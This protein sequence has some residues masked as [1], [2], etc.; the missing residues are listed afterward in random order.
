MQSLKRKYLDSLLD[1][2]LLYCLTSV[3]LVALPLVARAQTVI[4]T[5]PETEVADDVVTDEITEV[6]QFFDLS[7]DLLILEPVVQGFN[8]EDYAYVSQT[9]G[10][11]YISLSQMAQY[12]GLKYVRD[13]NNILTLWEADNE[14]VRYRIDFLTRKVDEVNMENN[15]VG[16]G[17]WFRDYDM[18]IIDQSIF[19]SS[20]FWQRL[21][22]AEVLVDPLNMQLVIKREKDFPAIGKIKAEKNR[23][24]KG[25]YS[26][27]DDGFENYE[28]DNRLFAEPVIDLSLG[29]GWGHNKMSHKTTNSDS[30]AVN[31]AMLAMGLDVNAYIQGS[32]YN[33]RKPTVRLSGSRT[34]LDNEN[35]YNLK[36]LKVGDISGLGQSY[37]TDAS[38]GRGVAVSSFKNLV[39]SADKTID[40]TGP[41]T[42]GWDVELYWNEQLIGFR[43]SGTNGEYNFPDVPVSYGLNIFK[44]V[45]YGPYGET[46]TEYE[47]YYSG[48]SPVKTG[49]FGYNVSVYQPYRYLVEDNRTFKYDGKDVPVI[50]MTGYYGATDKLT[51]MGGFTQTPSGTMKDE[52]TQQFGMAGAQYSLSGSSIQYNLEQNLDTQ[53]FG[54]HMEWQGNVYIGNIYAGYDKYNG[55]HSPVS[56][57][58]EEYLDEQIET[59]LSGTLPYN[60][61]YYLSYRTGK[62][63]DGD[64]PFENIS[65]RLSKQLMSGLN[66]SIEDNWYSYSG[67]RD[68]YNTLRAG[69]YKWWNKYTLQSYLTYRTNPDPEL[70]EI[71]TR[72]D[73]R[74]GRNT[75]MSGQWTRNMLNDMDYFSLSGGH[76]YPF[77]GLTATLETDRDFNLSAYLTY[78][79][80]FAKEPNR[81]G[82]IVNSNSKLSNTG[83]MMVEVKDEEGKPIEGVGLNANGLEKM[84][85]TDEDGVAILADLQTYEKTILS[86]DLETLI[87]ISL[88]PK[89]EYKKVV[90]R[91]GTIKTVEYEFIHRGAIEGKIAN[92]EGKR[93]FGY[94]IAAIDKDSKETAVT[95]A[96][97]DGYFI[98]DGIPYGTYS[99]I[100]SKEGK[101][102][103]EL[104]DVKVDDVAVYIEDEVVVDLDALEFF[105]NLD[106][107]IENQRIA[108]EHEKGYNPVEHLNN[109]F[110]F[111]MHKDILDMDPNQYIMT[112]DEIE[113]GVFDDKIIN[114]KTINRIEKE[115]FGNDIYSNI[116]DELEDLE[117]EIF[118]KEEISNVSPI[119]IQDKETAIKEIEN[120]IVNDKDNNVLDENKENVSS[121]I[122]DLDF[123]K[124]DLAENEALKE[125]IGN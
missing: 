109:T 66:V 10:K 123:I 25:F 116:E 74:T 21:L 45:F 115:V 44:L 93:L 41:L 64:E 58:G 20:G 55:I 1:Y 120:I 103:T 30:Y 96:D 48:T 112:I 61:P 51:L 4:S 50:D 36:T 52:V 125:V 83:T 38:Y 5:A 60:I 86:A 19:F 104:Y 88:Q 6:G 16:E 114:S 37:F 14:N 12:L 49:E 124:N 95:F 7:G 100:I 31:V 99:V 35:K 97:M 69:I 122:S 24:Q 18:D 15:V 78:N 106:R 68:A 90:L 113:E 92:P 34:Y 56:L 2:K 73:W 76:V 63:E 28:F 111:D 85:Y 29:K 46:R 108:S 13:N 94:Q 62:L 8:L 32:S 17:F 118:G 23:S 9:D 3:L 119:V 101:T 42:P 91:P 11:E 26:F 59:R 22:G 107:E 53:R 33:D 77:G 40:I 121:S 81:N 70:T 72:L 84:V 71:L 47:R 82:I 105:E 89:E 80:S 67:S 117:N 75:Y 98:L 57:Y 102:L 27:K 39:M 54:H 87:D 79:V 65:A 43:Q 110:P